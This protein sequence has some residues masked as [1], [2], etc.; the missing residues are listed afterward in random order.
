MTLCAFAVLVFQ[1]I[2]FQLLVKQMF[3]VHQLIF[4]VF[5]VV[6]TLAIGFETN[7]NWLSFVYKQK[8][9]LLM[10]V[11]KKDYTVDEILS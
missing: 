7:V 9:I 5:C 3:L 4:V 1:Q 8:I 2:S 10:T 11:Y 6:H